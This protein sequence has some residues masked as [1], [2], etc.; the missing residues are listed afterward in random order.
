[1][2]TVAKIGI[3]VA[4]GLGVAAIVAYLTLNA[5]ARN[6]V[7]LACDVPPKETGLIASRQWANDCK[8]KCGEMIGGHR[9][10]VYGG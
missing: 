2:R 6:G 7:N 4:I 10:G 9:H 5:I 1:M 8:I 3:W